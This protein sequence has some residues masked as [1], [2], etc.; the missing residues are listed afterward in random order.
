MVRTSDVAGGV[1]EIGQ[2]LSGR[3]GCPED[4]GVLNVSGEVMSEPGYF[5]FGPEA[6]CYG[7]CSSGATARHVTNSLYDATAA[8]R[9]HGS[10]VEL[11]FDPR[12]ILDNLRCE[13]YAPTGRGVKVLRPSGVVQSMYYKVRPLLGVS[14]RRRFQKFYFRGWENIPF[15]KWPVDRTVETL[16]EQLLIV[17]MKARNLERVPF[18]WFW[19]EGSP[20]CTM[21]THDVETSAG[22]KFCAE[23]MDL[24]D[25]FGIKS[26]FHIIPERRYRV[27][28]P[29]LEAIR[30][31]GFEIDVH[32]LNHDGLLMC[33]REEFHRRAEQINAYGKQFGAQGFRSA[34]M[35]RN[36]DWY[37][38]LD[39]AYDMSVPNVAHLDPQQGG[40]CTVLPFFA[41]K[42]LEL[43][44]TT[45]QDYSLFHILNKYSIELWKTQIGL[46]REKHG[47]ISF[48]VH[49]D[50]IIDRTARGVYR[51]LLKY[52]AEL[53]SGGKTWIALPREVAAWWRLRGNLKLLT[54][55][56]TLR[57]VGEGKE[58]ARVAYAVLKN[59]RLNYEVGRGDIASPDMGECQ[60]NARLL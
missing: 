41:G 5:R 11:P 56:G 22:L 12:Q 6:V 44:L 24:N 10:S 54:V 19:P 16:F 34:V 26:S 42:M 59:G 40:C 30:Q 46:V 15:P 14:A 27:V 37:D 28:E 31:R 50:Y 52:L 45:T 48:I 51:E 21:M 17:T 9:I 47:L 57:I 2:L 3:F 49:P 60:M 33:D 38:E 53:Q 1:P 55:G 58:R 13:R 23:L 25:A 4:I 18:I 7:Q 20:S 36:V 8:L 32:D 43:P 39:F 35:Y 29:V